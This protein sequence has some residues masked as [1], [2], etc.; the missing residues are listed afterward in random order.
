[1]KWVTFISLLFL[2]SSAY[3]R[4]VFRRDA[5]KSEIITRYKE[6]GEQ[7]FN[8]LVMAT[9]SQYL[10]KTA[11]DDLVKLTTEVTDLAKACVADSLGAECNKPL[12][13]IFGE[14]A[15]T[16]ANL[17]ETYGDMADCCD[18]QDLERF[19]CLVK[20][21]EDKPD[22]P[23]IQQTDPDTHCISFEENSQKTLGQLVARLS[24]KFPQAVFTEITKMATDLIKIFQE[25]C[26]GDL[27]EGVHDRMTLSNYTCDNQ[28]TISKKLG[29]CCAK[30]KLEK[31]HCIVELEDDK[32]D[33]L[34]SLAAD[35]AEDKDVCKNYAEA[36]D[37]FLGTFLYEYSRSHPEYG[38]LLLLRIAKAYEARLE[39]CCAEADPPACYGN[40]FEEFQPLV[41]E[42]QNLVKQNCDLYE[43]LGEYNFQNAL[44]IRYTQK[45][46]QVSTPTLVEAS[47]NLG[48]VAT[49][50]CKL[51]ETHRM[52][53]IE[54]HLSAVLNTL[55]VMHEKNPVSDRVTKCCSESF[56][57]KRACFSALQVDDTYTPKE[58]NAET[59][60]FH[61][62]IC[63]LPETEQQIKKQM[64]LRMGAALP[65]MMATP[66][67]II[68][69]AAPASK[70]AGEPQQGSTESAQRQA[71]CPSAVG[72]QAGMEAQRWID[73]ESN[74]CSL[75]YLIKLSKIA[76]QLSTEELISLDK[77]MVTALTTCC[78]KGEEFACVYSL[79]TTQLLLWQ[80]PV[81][82]MQSLLDQ[83][84][85]RASPLTSGKPLVFRSGRSGSKQLATQLLL[86]QP[87]GAPVVAPSP[88]AVLSRLLY[89]DPSC[90]CLPLQWG[91]GRLAEQLYFTKF[92][93]F[94]GYCPIRDAFPMGEAHPAALSWSQVSH[95]LFF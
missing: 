72:G 46:P 40:V 70:G 56:V 78:T 51:P 79:R 47:R 92:P 66:S 75:S 49:K 62:D 82:L 53:C 30:P 63:T 2:F 93:A 7:H 37:I 68:Q 59:F 80:L 89:N 90:P 8:D 55:C 35:Y 48:K 26:K 38:S 21:K 85:H 81:A 13:T 69:H 45:T 58:F 88:S 4:G 50:C 71:Q 64:C 60:T 17:R 15:C 27:L 43:Q 42:P 74:V 10:Q 6:F 41:A 86:R 28:D 67:G 3:S 9:F 33:N 24:R 22:L 29:P 73:L 95:Y 11:Y 12:D 23:R 1:M 44:V 65:M 77:E 57:N 19:Q 84:T 20:H 25:F 54:D 32:P 61:A 36:K 31:Y 5:D 52:P 94:R 16:I 14:K 18:K 34:P 76:F 83:A 87:P 39:K 91:E